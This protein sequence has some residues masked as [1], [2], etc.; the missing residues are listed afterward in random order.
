MKIEVE[1]TAERIADLMVSACECNDMTASWCEGVY[2]RARSISLQEAGK[3][4]TLSEP[5]YSDPKLYEGDFILEIHE[6]TIE[7]DP[8]KV[9][10]HRCDEI[11][12]AKA[13]KLMAEKHGRHFG[14]FMA[15]NDDNT[16]AD[17]FLQL[18]ALGD[19]IYG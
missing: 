14:D 8:D 1:I 6:I 4:T 18:V 9:T 7:S 17:V 3:L 5:W 16:T 12:F 10:V 11:N 15:E 13:F 19:V 2:L